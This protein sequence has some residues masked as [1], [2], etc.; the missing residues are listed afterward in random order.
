MAH[1]IAR[2]SRSAQ[3]VVEE[4][5]ADPAVGMAP[6]LPVTAHWAGD[7]T[8][9]ITDLRILARSGIGE[10]LRLLR[11]RVDCERVCPR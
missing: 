7:V 2:R 4:Y 8:R 9:V 11:T 10:E 3:R 6:R 5:G 1:E